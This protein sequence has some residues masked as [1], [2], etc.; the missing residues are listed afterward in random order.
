MNI[1]LRKVLAI[2]RKDFGHY[3]VSPI[4]Y[5]VLAVFFFVVGYFFFL[6]SVSPYPVASMTPIFQNAVILLL[7]LT[8]MITMKL[9]SE[10]EKSQTAE[11]LR[12][13]PVTL[14]EIVLGKYFAV[15]SFAVAMISS[16]L[17]YLLVILYAGNPDPGVLFAN[18]L[19]FALAGMAFFSLGLLASTLSENQIVAAVT[20]YG[21]LLMLWVIGAAGQSVQGPAGAVFQYLSVFD[22]VNDFMQGV[23]DLGHVVYFASLIFIGLFL[24]VK[25]LEGKRV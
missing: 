4:G 17:L 16:T 5:V 2:A 12:T 21:I 23:I 7:F 9:W 24:S 8:P 25:I 3:F 18:Y 13:S 6:I 22:H 19:G 10:E 1:D 15:C 11:L 14:W 20:G